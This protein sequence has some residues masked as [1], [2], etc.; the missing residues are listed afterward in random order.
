[1]KRKPCK[2]SRR[3][4]RKRDESKREQKR[5]KEKEQKEKAE[6]KAKC[7]EKSRREKR[8]REEKRLKQ[9][10]K[11]HKKRA[12]KTSLSKGAVLSGGNRAEAKEPRKENT[13]IE[14]DQ[15]KRKVRVMSETDAIDTNEGCV[16]FDDVKE[17]N[18]RTW[19]ECSCGR[20]LLRTTHFLFHQQ[21]LMSYV[22]TVL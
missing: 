14:D 17:A 16:C 6:R 5:K 15:P 22:H 8:Q 4:K 21:C 11:G 12:Q 20:W 1:M 13:D 9:L 19:I 3:K 7:E 2:S 18:G 10:E